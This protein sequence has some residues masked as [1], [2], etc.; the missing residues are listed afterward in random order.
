M[1]RGYWLVLIIPRASSELKITTPGYTGIAPDPC[2]KQ[3]YWVGKPYLWKQSGEEKSLKATQK[4]DPYFRFIT[5]IDP[6]RKK[7]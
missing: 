7:R 5:T 6:K 3:G 2:D 4:I 1:G